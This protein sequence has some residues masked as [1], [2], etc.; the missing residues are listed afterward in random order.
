MRSYFFF[1]AWQPLIGLGLLP[2]YRGFTITLRQTTLGRTHLDE[3]SACRRDLYLTTHNTH[4]RQTDMLPAGF[5]PA[6]FSRELPQTYFLYRVAT[7]IGM[8]S[9]TASI[10]QL[11]LKKDVFVHL[12]SFMTLQ[13]EPPSRIREGVCGLRDG[14]RAVTKS[15]IYLSVRN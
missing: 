1:M 4:N 14:L 8:W 9:Y 2:H 7:A 6:V 10:F 15:K 11:L 5:E 12:I 13:E 3:W